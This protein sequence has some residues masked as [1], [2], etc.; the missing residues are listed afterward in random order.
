AV[1]TW[2]QHEDKTLSELCKRLVNRK[3]FKIEM[4]K[5]IF[6]SEK[7][8]SLLKQTSEKLQINTE[9]AKYFVFADK[10][11]NSA[12][13]LKTDHINILFKNGT[14]MDIAQASDQMNIN[15]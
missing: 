14:T 6:P 5:N 10:T 12:Y 7:I 4:S 11:S 2:M 9:E 3:L 15:V 1:K 8:D 13:N